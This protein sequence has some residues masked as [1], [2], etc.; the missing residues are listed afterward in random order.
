MKEC[1]MM[2]E[3]T[4]WVEFHSSPIHGIGGFARAAVPKGT[5]VIEY[6]GQVID[7]AESLRQCEQNNLFIFALDA[8]YDVDGNVPWNV[9]RWLN[10]SCAP[11]CEAE[12]WENR[13]WIVALRHI[14]AGEEITFNYGF[15][16]EDY[17]SYPCNCG[18]SA[19]VGFIVAEQFFPNIRRLHDLGGVTR[20]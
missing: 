4:E 9:A 7:K 20:A 14:D 11:N 8:A 1:G 18:S 2:I 16:L 17:K 3:S 13:I 5:R 6:V 15:D 19:C 12:L 10:H